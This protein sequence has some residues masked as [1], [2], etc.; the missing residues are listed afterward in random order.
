MKTRVNLETVMLR[1][2]R[3]QGDYL[4]SPFHVD[5]KAK[6]VKPKSGMPHGYDGQVSSL[7]CLIP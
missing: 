5:Y 1:E 4:T 7:A 3:W 6:L 2:A